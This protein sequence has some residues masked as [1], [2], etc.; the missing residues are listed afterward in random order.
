MPNW[1]EN[2]LTIYGSEDKINE[3]ENVIIGYQDHDRDFFGYYVPVPKESQNTLGQ[4]TLWGTKWEPD[5][6]DWY[7]DENTISISMNTAWGPPI[8]FYQQMEEKYDF[9]IEGSYYE[10]GMCFVGYYGGE[11]FDLAAMD[12]EEV[13]GE[14]PKDLDEMYNISEW[15]EQVEE[16]EKLEKEAEETKESDFDYD[17]YNGGVENFGKN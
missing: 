1:C 3:L 7:R 4:A 11:H 17:R 9:E 5:I 6:Y 15:L 12:S 16:E 10:P 2:N 13:R 8:E 14:I